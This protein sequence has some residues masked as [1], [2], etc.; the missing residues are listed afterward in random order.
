MNVKHLRDE[1]D[2]LQEHILSLN[3]AFFLY[4]NKDKYA[5]RE[6][7]NSN[8]LIISQQSLIRVI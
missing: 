3:K 6:K 5:D 1:F 7:V 8:Q 2:S 4:T